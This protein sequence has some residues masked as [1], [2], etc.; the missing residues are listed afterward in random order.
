L[1]CF[2]LELL[3]IN[4]DVADLSDHID[5]YDAVN[6]VLMSVCVQVQN[7]F[8]SFQDQEIVVSVLLGAQL[9]QDFA[10]F[11]VADTQFL[12][13]SADLGLQIRDLHLFMLDIG[14]L[15]VA[16]GLRSELVFVK[17][18]GASVLLVHAA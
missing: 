8:H 11:V 10:P 18:F 6:F 14:E 15:S 17:N 12:F 1:G 2:L 16:F 5:V 4:G 7:A 13:Q 9:C 3:F